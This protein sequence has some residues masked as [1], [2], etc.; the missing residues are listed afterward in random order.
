MIMKLNEQPT[1]TMSRVM[2]N[3]EVHVRQRAII[4]SMKH[5]LSPRSIRKQKNSV[6][7]LFLISIGNIIEVGEMFNY[8]KDESHFHFLAEIR[9]NKT[10]I[11]MEA[12]EAAV[13]DSA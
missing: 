2:N 11:T 3:L 4:D 10:S 13:G 9:N 12:M 7:C 5:E 6:E 8:R 1:V